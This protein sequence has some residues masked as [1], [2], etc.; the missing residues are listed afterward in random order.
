MAS[1]T[2]T[3]PHTPATTVSFLATVDINGQQVPINTGDVTQGLKN[4]VFTLANPIA[5]GSFDDFLDYLNKN[6]G[7]PLKSADLIGYINDIPGDP[8]VLL[9]L[10]NALLKITSTALTVTV[11]NINVAAKT[12]MLGVTFPVDLALTSF[13]TINS[14]GLVVSRTDTTTTSPTSP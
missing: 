4:F 10:R 6:I 9:D 1:P 14:I 8:A 7:I 3:S 11:L 13:L 2:V 5:L 12:F